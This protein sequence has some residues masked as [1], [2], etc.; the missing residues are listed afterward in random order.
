RHIANGDPAIV[1]LLVQSDSMDPIHGWRIVAD[2]FI[3]VARSRFALLL[4]T[5]PIL[6][7]LLAGLIIW[8]SISATLGAMWR[9]AFQS[10]QGLS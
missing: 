9:S 1:E 3:E 4:S 10:I 7:T 8:M 6:S 2:H 5:G